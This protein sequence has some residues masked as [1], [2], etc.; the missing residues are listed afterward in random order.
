MKKKLESKQDIVIG[1][2][3]KQYNKLLATVG[4]EHFFSSDEVTAKGKRNVMFGLTQPGLFS[5]NVVFV[6]S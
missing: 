6:P 4:R 5:W 2:S 1:I 3:T